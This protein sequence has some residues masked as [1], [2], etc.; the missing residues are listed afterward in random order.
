VQAVKKLE[1]LD[2]SFTVIPDPK[3]TSDK[4]HTSFY[5]SSVPREIDMAFQDVLQAAGAKCYVARDELAGLP[6]WNVERARLTLAQMVQQGVCMIDEGAPN[7]R[8]LFWFPVL[9]EAQS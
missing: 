8:T 7:G 1:T 4:K 5:V 2:K 3:R 9:F 6:H